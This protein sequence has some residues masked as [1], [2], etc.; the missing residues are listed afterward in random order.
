[1]CTAQKE[2]FAQL[3]AWRHEAEGAGAAQGGLS[4]LCPSL[5]VLLSK[6]PEALPNT[7]RCLQAAMVEQDR[8]YSQIIADVEREAANYVTSSENDLRGGRREFA[9]RGLDLSHVRERW[10]CAVELLL[11]RQRLEANA[12]LS[13]DRCAVSGVDLKRE[14]SSQAQAQSQFYSDMK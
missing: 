12:A 1:M 2:L 3:R 13:L 11:Q 4:T 5:S 9:K 7:A 14:T 10:G 6:S 8:V